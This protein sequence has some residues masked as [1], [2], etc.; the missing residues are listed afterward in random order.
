[1]IWTPGDVPVSRV[2]WRVVIGSTLSFHVH[3][4]FQGYKSLSL[5]KLVPGKK[6]VG[7]GKLD[8]Y[9]GGWVNYKVPVLVVYRE[10]FPFH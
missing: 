9:N 7:V 8:S 5:K 2:M 10:C 4:G 3:D 6:V 1:M